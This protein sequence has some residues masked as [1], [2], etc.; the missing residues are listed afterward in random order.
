MFAANSRIVGYA[1]LTQNAGE[2]ASPWS[3][4]KSDDPPELKGEF[5]ARRA[6]LFS[7]QRAVDSRFPSGAGR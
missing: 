1:V 2:I 7:V 5:S 3:G 4:R 6:C